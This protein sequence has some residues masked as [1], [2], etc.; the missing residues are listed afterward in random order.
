MKQ[1][2]KKII[3]I[4][5]LCSIL[6]AL[7]VVFYWKGSENLSKIPVRIRPFLGIQKEKEN[8]IDIVILGDSESLTSIS[9]LELWQVNG[10]TSYVCGQSGQKIQETYYMLKTALKN[11]TPQ[12]VILETNT[13]FR[14]QNSM[15][16]FKTSLDEMTNYY[17]PIFRYHDYWKWLFR[18]EEY[19]HNIDY[20][21]F[22]MKEHV[23]SYNGDAYMIETDVKQDISPFV[24]LY[25]EKI[26][27]ECKKKNIELILLSTPSP[28]NYNYQ[29]HNALEQYAK[30]KNLKY[31]DL[32]LKVEEVGV[33]WKT[34]TL[35][36]G[37]HLNISGAQKV[38]KYLGK[39]LENQYDLK[40]HRLDRNFKEWN[41]NSI[42]YE[43][44]IAEKLEHIRST[45]RKQSKK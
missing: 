35:D 3:F 43:K 17:F 32:N 36:K 22:K 18:K 34:D 8:S 15:D 11:Q 27:K 10:T 30:H 2:G 23:D 1:L 41:T 39:Y 42:A 28:V 33:D 44:F 45:D 25:L 29:K 21:G 19:H 31:L 9:P 38:T 12:L 13:L 7:S 24:K 6:I 14:Y 20:K 5:V 40:D 26:L 37:D 16:Q 4:V